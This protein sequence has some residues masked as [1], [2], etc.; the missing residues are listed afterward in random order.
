MGDLL[1]LNKADDSHSSPTLEAGERISF[2]CFLTRSEAVR[3]KL[4]PIL[5]TVNMKTP[6]THAGY[7]GFAFGIR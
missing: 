7:E 6:I 3:Y 2:A 4:G 5:P 1:I